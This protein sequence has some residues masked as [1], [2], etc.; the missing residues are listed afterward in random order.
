MIG[1][2]LVRFD[3]ACTAHEQS[4]IGQ[5]LSRVESMGDMEAVPD[6]F[7]PPWLVVIEEVSDGRRLFFANRFGEQNALTGET[8]EELADSI[9]EA[10]RERED[11]AE[12]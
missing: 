12:A 1:E 10:F 2:P 4:L 6:L 7:G 11:A 3:G 5:A 8:V 9:R